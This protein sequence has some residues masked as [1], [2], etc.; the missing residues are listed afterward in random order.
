MDLYQARA[1]NQLV[2]ITYFEEGGE[3]GEVGQN[4]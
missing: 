4:R 1:Y 2:Y 3:G